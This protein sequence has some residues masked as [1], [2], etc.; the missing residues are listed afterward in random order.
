MARIQ[1]ALQLDPDR[2]PE[3]LAFLR[4]R[5]TVLRE[6]GGQYWVEMEDNQVDTLMAQ[7]IGVYPRADSDVAELPSVVF[8]PATE[9]PQPPEALRAPEPQGDAYYLVHF[10]APIDKSW[11]H[12][13]AE[14]GGEF[15]H[16]IPAQSAVFRFAPE[17]AAAVRALETVDFLGPWHPAYAVGLDLAGAQEPF[18]ATSLRTLTVTLPEDTEE[19]NLTVRTFDAVDPEELRAPLEAAG[20]TI[21]EEADHGFR[22]RAPQPRA[23]EILSVPGIFAA[24]LPTQLVLHNHHAGVI[25]GT[26]QV[27]SMGTVDF[28]VNLDGA[29]EIGAVVDSGFDVGNLAGAVPPAVPNPPG[30][31]VPR[32]HTAFHPALARC[33]RLLRNS[34]NPNNAALNV[35][36]RD[37]HGT[38]V[39]GTIAGDGTGGGGQGRGMAP[40]AALVGLGRLPNVTTVP[41]EFAFAQ[42]ARVINNSWGSN[43]NLPFVNQN[44]YTATEAHPV[45]RWC[46]S[47]PD[48]L[49]LFAAG[50]AE[51][52]TLPPG[53]VLDQRR[54]GLEAT[55][56]NVFTVGASENLHND[57][58]WRDSYRAMPWFAGRWNSA[59]FTATAGGAAAGFTTSDNADQMAMFSDRGEVRTGGLVNTGRIK[60]DVAA[61]GTNVLSCRSQWVRPPRPLPTVPPPPPPPPQPA[62]W[63]PDPYYRRNFDTIVPAGVDRPLYHFMDGTSMATPMVSGSALLV[64]QY[65]RTRFAQMR[66]PLLLE[67]VDE[68][69]GPAF[70]G[71][72]TLVT[73]PDGWVLAWVSPGLPADPRRI[74][75]MRY[76]RRLAAVDG[77][78]VVLQA[79]V[80]DL[81]AP[82]LARVGERTYLLHR[83]ADN[84]MR[85]S[86]YDRAL[87][88]VNGFGVNGV[89]TL[90]PAARGDALVS[91]DLLAVGAELACVYPAAG[92]DAYTFQRF[93][94]DTGAAIGAPVTV[95]EAHQSGPQR[96]MVHNGARYT[97]C[98]VNR[99][100]PTH[101]L[102]VRQVATNGTLL[103]AAPTVLVEEPMELRE[104][105]L[106]WD[107]RGGGRHLLV[108]CDARIQPGCEIYAL[109]LDAN[110]AA[111]GAPRA[112]VSVPVANRVRRPRVFAHPDAGFVL[113]WEDDTQ[114]GHFDV[115]TTFLGDDGR[116]DARISVDPTDAS[117]RA[118]LRLSD[119]PG[120]TEGF[121]SSGDAEGITV[122]YHSPDEINSDR[123]GVYA[124]NLTPGG[125]FEAQED[126]STPLLRSGRY[127]AADAL[128]H[129]SV[130]MF[131]VSAVW[132]GGAYY[133]LRQAP[134]APDNLLQWVRLNADGRVDGSYG[135][136]GAHS[137]P[138][139]LVVMSQEM[140]WTGTQLVSAAHHLLGGITVYLA[141]D[142]GAPV[143]G[144][145]AGG[146]AV[147]AEPGV[148]S[149]DVAPHL[150]TFTLPAPTVAV[151]YGVSAG[152][153]VQLRYQR[154]DAATGAQIG[155]TS[156]LALV[157]GVSRR[158]WYQFVNGEGRSITIYHRV[159]GAVSR[160]HSRRYDALGAPAGA[161]VN[162]SPAAGEGSNGVIARRP[163][164]VN[165][166]NREYAAA[167]QYRA[168][169]AAH[170][171]IHF[172]RL[173]RAGAPMTNPPL[174]APNHPVRDVTAVAA[175]V[176][177]PADR[178]AVEPQLVCTYTHER[179]ASPP[180]IPAGR[181]LPAWSPSY[182][183]AWIGV[184]PDGTRRLFFTLLDENGRRLEVPSP[185]PPAGLLVAPVPV[186]ILQVSGDTPNV[187]DFKLV[188][189]GRVFFI[190]WTEEEA[191]VLRHRHTMVNRHGSQRAYDLPSAALLRA[192]LVNGA[193]N[194][195]S[196]PLPNAPA[197]YGWGR[198]NLR[199]TLSPAP[200]VT[201]HVRDDCALGPG[202]TA[203]YRFRLPPGTAMLRVTL[204]WTDPP[205][206]RLVNRLHLTVRAPVP[207]GP[208]PPASE[209]RGNL[210]GAAPGT[211][212]LS[213]AVP[214]PAVAADA[215]EDVQTFKQVVLANPPAGE[216]VVEVT[217]AVFGVDPFNQQN[218]QPFA[219]VFAGTG[220][221]VRFNLPLPAVAGRPVY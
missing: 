152:A 76:S 87:Q 31:A 92:G 46:F 207:P 109:F 40:R 180:A 143:P 122:L 137:V 56:K 209:Y 216:Y 35:P 178:D 12:R 175:A 11:L 204:N 88:P 170:W 90:A 28:L 221:E 18:T 117:G 199:Q 84:S 51:Q 111:I 202:R 4:D 190:T 91:P 101:R 98:G 2:A 102:M 89:V 82:R 23:N 20:A 95:F 77:A 3:Q 34:N 73:H 157:T 15:V 58:G 54:L 124:L 220:P 200:P 203:T 42:G 1:A 119:T 10:I 86:C 8:S 159:A 148:V 63:P 139:G 129:D 126:P 142:Q 79:A 50:N 169:A 6:A 106:V 5:V 127:V 21:V 166:P 158:G 99:A 154:L 7:G 189:N 107:P 218:L 66:R 145:G 155:A 72:P 185:P 172:C 69:G 26:D 125:A 168:N 114:D 43:F 118:L 156:D 141:D 173:N 171:E 13:I 205:G 219:L 198:V 108:W 188:W 161:E 112:V 115:Y 68:A 44:R 39:A 9:T 113:Q 17:E 135:V 93:R 19:G 192:T 211:T 55:A 67:G 29:G 217:A 179:W 153:D 75:A 177:W 80:G 132:T 184:L 103:G 215:H 138:A 191:G 123:V 196:T 70:S 210:W 105:S 174:P 183:L 25:L 208:P 94:T 116:V 160:V 57:G 47:H 24:E 62:V 193:T 45:D 187:R 130:G 74:V 52:D 32:L 214:L 36:D 100:G 48:V 64:R 165:S 146:A 206:P 167:W 78:P 134:G 131:D 144:F 176:D 195:A 213:R 136:A 96:I 81:A 85:L 59:A 182:G 65:Y 16:S 197:G 60:P 149:S 163:T 33:I 186:S 162:L 71:R 22:V 61:P 140:L 53:G 83:H 49:V 181:R 97:V 38:H 41:F 14:I 128:S 150:G 37:P 121:A 147:A 30:P 201:L 104:P 110:G 194:I 27:R 133:V 151:A 164:A 212:H 120:D